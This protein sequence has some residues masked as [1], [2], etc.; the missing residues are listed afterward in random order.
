MAT[1]NKVSGAMWLTTLA[2]GR[3]PVGTAH[4]AAEAGAVLAGLGAVRTSDWM[5]VASDGCP[6]RTAAVTLPG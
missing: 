1:Y 4:N 6:L 5:L 2:D 3:T